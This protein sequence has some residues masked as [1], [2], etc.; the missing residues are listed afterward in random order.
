MDLSSVPGPPISTIWSTPLPPV[1]RGVS[2]VRN[3]DEDE[4]EGEDVGWGWRGIG[5][6]YE[7]QGFLIPVR[8]FLVIDQMSSTQFLCD[9]Q[10]DVG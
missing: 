4:G 1:C 6:T 10:F 9:L 7:F 5:L 8:R 2:Q 3:D